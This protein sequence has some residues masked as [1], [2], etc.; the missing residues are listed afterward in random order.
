MGGGRIRHA[1]FGR[2]KSADRLTDKSA[3]GGP[4]SGD[5]D[6]GGLECGELEAAREAPG[7]AR[8]GAAGGGESE[9]GGGGEGGAAEMAR[10]SF[11]MRMI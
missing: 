4:G 1:V 10:S 9:G 2:V 5:A 7:E 8:A 3:L 6:R 11:M